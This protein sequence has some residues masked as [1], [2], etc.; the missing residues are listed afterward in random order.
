MKKKA[1]VDLTKMKRET[2]DVKTIKRLPPKVIKVS[3][4]IERLPTTITHL[5]GVNTR[6]R[7]C[8][9]GR[10]PTE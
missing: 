2:V 1:P 5:D 9:G 6:A 4:K 10:M 7:T 3:P 8:G